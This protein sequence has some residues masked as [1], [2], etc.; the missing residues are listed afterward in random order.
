MS[1]HDEPTAR[2]LTIRRPKARHLASIAVAAMLAASVGVFTLDSV[3]AEP[4]FSQQSAKAA[5]A[6]AAP[7]AVPGFSALV[8][9]VKP[10]V[11]S[12]RVKARPDV[13]N[14][15]MPEG[16]NPF[17]GT[18]F[19]RFFKGM[20]GNG[21]APGKIVQGQGSGFFVSA[22]GYLVTNNHVVQRA[23]DVEVVMDNG[24]TLKAKVVGTDPK[25]DLALLK[26]EGR[27]DFPFV[28]LANEQ[29]KIGEWVVAMGNPFGLGGTVT[30]G[31]VSAH[32]RDIGSGPYDDY[33]QIDAPVNRGNS[34]GPTFNLKGEVIGV[35]TAIYSPSGGS[36]GIAFDI[37][38]STVASVI[39]QLQNHGQ[40]TRGWLGVQ[41]QN[42]TPALADS[43]G[44]KSSDGA[45]VSEP[46]QGGPAAKAGLKSGDVIV[47]VDS[48]PVKDT[49]VLAR[50]IAGI[51]PDKRVTLHIVRNG[52]PQTLDLTLGKLAEK[53]KQTASAATNDGKA[54]DGLGLSVAPA[55][56]VSD[57]DK[58]LA[59]VAV[60]PDGRAAEAGLQV[61]DVIVKAG[62]SAVT[63]PDD[64]ASALAAAKAGGRSNTLV[65]VKRNNSDIYIALPSAV[66]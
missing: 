58:G 39:P 11:V 50:T 4:L 1:I 16:Q 36:V 20:P 34:G 27:K 10:A 2:P 6:P 33:I 14:T 61:G 24:D 51:G 22:D 41:I 23:V 56:A 19:E 28:R 12:V 55:A 47:A 37:P 31:I 66:G 25:S 13:E 17:E 57:S 54:L 30:A 38:A 32:N 43:L 48:T 9:A 42:V 40:V 21:A 26:V 18:P 65:L 44:L 49:R 53:R 45:L 7:A 5:R 63:N 59:V 46:Q 64:L 35:N 60:D 3:R 62:K 29:P 8:E 52:E 15:V